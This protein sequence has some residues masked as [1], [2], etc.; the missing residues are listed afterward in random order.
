MNKKGSPIS[1]PFTYEDIITEFLPCYM[2]NIMIVDHQISADGLKKFLEDIKII[3]DSTGCISE[4]SEES[5]KPDFAELPISVSVYKD[6]MTSFIFMGM[7]TSFTHFIDG[8][9]ATFENSFVPLSV[10]G[11]NKSSK[12]QEAAQEFIQFILSEEEQ[13]HDIER[14][15]FP[16]NIKAFENMKV[17]NYWEGEWV[18]RYKNGQQGFVPLS[19][20]SVSDMKELIEYCKTVTER[21][22]VDDYIQDIIIEFGKNYILGNEPVD[23]TVELIENKI[24]IYSEE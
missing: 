23:K 2:H 11:I 14:A 18:I 15:G 1:E 3:L 22:Y 4:Y 7:V 10:I 13:M 20:V 17:P 21:A 19:D 12:Q 6:T 16:I 9:F 24:S 8:D 5:Y